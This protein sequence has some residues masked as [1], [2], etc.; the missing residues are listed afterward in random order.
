MNSLKATFPGEGAYAPVNGL[1]IYFEIAGTGAPLVLIHGGGS[2]LN[3]SFRR[4]MPLLAERYRVIGVELQ[5][6][7]HTSD[8]G[9]PSSFEQDADDVAGLLKHLGVVKA[10]ILGF[11]NGGNTAMRIA[12]RH[13]AI[14]DKL[15]IASAFYKA[16]GMLP[17][18]FEGMQQASLQNMPM[19]LQEAYLQITGDEYGLQVMHDRDKTR[20]LEF[21]DWPDEDLGLIMA[22]ALLL[23]GDQDVVTPEHAVEMYRKIPHARLS[24][25][26]GT[27]GSF[28]GELCSAVPGSRIPEM[29]VELIHEFF[30]IPW[31]NT[32]S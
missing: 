31:E 9:T 21:R 23:V 8:R 29:V 10:H 32:T 13:P 5:A 7:G 20:M 28:L 11:S 16:A 22:P 18:F 27:H 12:I 2:T 17:G 19:P 30:E 14:V 6:H 1:N 3:T 4:I 26:P 24:I 15:V 25:L